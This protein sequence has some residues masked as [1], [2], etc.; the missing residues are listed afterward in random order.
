MAVL[1]ETSKGDVVIDL[2]TDDCPITTKNFLKL[3]KIKYYNNCLFHNVQRNFIVQTGDPSGTGKGGTSIYGKLYGDQARF[4]EDE[5]RP[6]LKHG[7][8]G[9]V[10]MASPGEGLNASQ[11]YITTGEELDSLDGRHTIFGRVAEGW[12][13]LDAI[14]EA[15]VDAEGRP[16][17]NIRIR[18]TIVLDDPFPDPPELEALIPPA[19]PPPEFGEG[20]R[21]EDDWV[22]TEETRPAEEVEAETRRAEAH[23]R[24]VVLEMVGDL[25]DADAKPP[26]NMLFICKLNPVTSE[27]DLEIIFSRFGRVTSCDIIRDWK[28]GDSLNYGFIGFDTDESCEAAYFKMNNAVIDDR[29]VR[30]DFSQSVHHL[31]RQF[32][33][34]GKRGDASM[35]RMAEQHQRQE[36]SRIELKNNPRGGGGGGGGRGGGGGGGGGH[37]LLLLGHDEAAA[38]AAVAAAVAAAAAD[39]HRAGGGGGAKRSRHGD[40]DAGDGDGG[41]RRRHRH[42]DEPGGGGGCGGSAAAAAASRRDAETGRRAAPRDQDPDLDRGRGR[43]RERERPDRWGRGAGEERGAGEGRDAAPPRQQPYES[44]RD[45]GRGEHDRERERRRDRDREDDPRVGADRRDRDRD[46]DRDREA[47]LARGGDRDGAQFATGLCA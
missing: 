20:D 27:E 29:R 30:V 24:A 11:F 5:L 47:P 37:D 45:G 38:A 34:G 8:R 44:G 12:E 16:F 6:H 42:H 14:N 33:K 46:R 43:D 28:T 35:G 15:F 39:G 9:L 10:G 21:L 19:S 23:H 36:K 22:P 1:L 25:P 40:G 18:H 26:P 4:F 2:L 41:D 17:Q 31:W 32:K 3:C 13:V 7:R